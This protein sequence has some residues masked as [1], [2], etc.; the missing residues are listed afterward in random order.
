MDDQDYVVKAKVTVVGDSFSG[1]STICRILSPLSKAG[2]PKGP[3]IGVDFF[4]LL[5]RTE[6]G[7]ALVQLWDIGGGSRFSRYADSFL[8][9]SVACI[10]V[11]DLSAEDNAET[12][13]RWLDSVSRN[14]PGCPVLVLGN[15]SDLVPAEMVRPVRT[16]AA[17]ESYGEGSAELAPVNLTRTVTLF[18]ARA[19]AGG[20]RGR[21]GV[22]YF[23]RGDPYGEL[24]GPVW[25]IAHG[26]LYG[27][28]AIL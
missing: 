1:K 24:E 7:P 22:H 28:C 11:F 16:M 27:C 8:Q 9:G 14:C 13:A 19:V 15:K 20:P 10:V 5:V 17:G 4:E 18:L 12:V 25:P 21:V 23:P 2:A 3:T 26:F 6:A